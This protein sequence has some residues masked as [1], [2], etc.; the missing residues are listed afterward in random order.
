M[1]YVGYT[2]NTEEAKSRAQ[3][4]REKKNVLNLLLQRPRNFLIY[5]Y[6]FFCVFVLSFQIYSFLA[7]AHINSHLALLRSSI[8][9][10][11]TVRRYSRAIFFF[12]VLSF[13][14]GLLKLKILHVRFVSW[15][16]APFIMHLKMNLLPSGGFVRWLYYI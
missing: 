9:F 6:D 5:F 7:L 4:R 1:L 12:F 16:S 10:W 8:T 13:Y 3:K 2:A 15:H 14:L 11:C